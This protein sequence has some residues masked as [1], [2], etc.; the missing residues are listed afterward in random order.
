MKVKRALKRFLYYGWRRKCPL[1]NR[2]FRR[3][4]SIPA[5]RR[6]DA[7]CPYCCSKERHRLL[8]LY[9]LQK[10][11]VLHGKRML[12][13]APDPSFLRMFRRQNG[14]NYHTADLKGDYVDERVD[15]C[16]LPHP[17]KSFDFVI[18]FH[19]LEHILDDRIA[20]KELFRV[21]KDSG[22]LFVMVP[23]YGETTF[24]DSSVVTPAKRKQLFGQEDHVRKYGWDIL[25]RFR[26]AGFETSLFTADD[27]NLP[28]KQV[29]Y[30]GACLP[31]ETLIVA[32]PEQHS[33]APL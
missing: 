9:L 14:L 2:T 21:L 28:K 33:R 17:D 6:K 26:A 5:N 16:S 1:C 13:F 31:G 19:I 24:E 30:F 29:E 20:L 27:L 8:C 25:D 7:E 22:T 18:C 3:F 32:K 4:F 15:I 10:K 23:L 12:H 11:L